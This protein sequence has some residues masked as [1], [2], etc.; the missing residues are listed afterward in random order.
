M[1][2][3]LSKLREIPWSCQTCLV[4]FENVGRKAVFWFNQMSDKR[5]QMSCEAQKVSAYPRIL[6]HHTTCNSRVVRNFW[7]RGR[8]GKN[9]G[10][11]RLL[12]NRSIAQNVLNCEKVA[13]ANDRSWSPLSPLAA[14]PVC[15]P[16]GCL[17][18]S[19]SSHTTFS[20][21][22]PVFLVPW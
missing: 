6:L 22:P 21:F 10:R 14:Y 18:R 15:G 16:V 13:G 9:R 2:G 5:L 1:K 7:S 12:F 11:N 20:P 19:T 4:N 8:I 17:N 3:T